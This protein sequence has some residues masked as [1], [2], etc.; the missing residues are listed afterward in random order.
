MGKGYRITSNSWEYTGDGIGLAL[1]AGADLI[2]MEMVQFHPTGMV[3]PPSVRG[4]LVTESVRGD[5]GT[6]KNTAGER[7]MFNYIPE[8]FKGETADNEAEADRWY[9]DKKNNRRTADLLPR[10][11]VARAINAEV[12]AG[13][14]S[15]T[16]AWSPTSARRARPTTS[17]RACPRFTTSSRGRPTATSPRSRWKAGRPR[18]QALAERP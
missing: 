18:P 10:D 3:W 1:E 6:L 17:A 4:I 7:F 16:A 2:D 15:P 9:V 8:F 14:G 12:K 5:G 13:R 11:E